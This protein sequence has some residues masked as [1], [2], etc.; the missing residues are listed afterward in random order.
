[1]HG[2]PS[3]KNCGDFIDNENIHE[4]DEYNRQITGGPSESFMTL[5]NPEAEGQIY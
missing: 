4:G 1:M 2:A 5:E 3:N